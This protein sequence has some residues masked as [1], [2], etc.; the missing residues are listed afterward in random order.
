MESSSLTR[1]SLEPLVPSVSLKDDGER[2]KWGVSHAFLH[3]YSLTHFTN[4]SWRAASS[5]LKRERWLPPT[6][7]I[8]K[9]Q[10]RLTLGPVSLGASNG[11]TLSCDFVFHLNK[12]Q[13]SDVSGF[14]V[15]H[16]QKPTLL[17]DRPP[18]LCL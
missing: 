15:C 14:L 7:S 9:P 12:K 18:H 3:G 13:L 5:L 2:G 8:I 10:K 4:H 1:R 17:I 6:C 16:P 11:T